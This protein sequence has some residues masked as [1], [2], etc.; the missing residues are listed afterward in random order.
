MLLPCS[1]RDQH[2][3]VA[4][5]LG[6]EHGESK[7]RC[8]HY[9]DIGAGC[10]GDAHDVFDLDPVSGWTVWAPVA[11]V[12]DDPGWPLAVMRMSKGDSRGVELLTDPTTACFACQVTCSATRSAALHQHANLDAHKQSAEQAPA[13]WLTQLYTEHVSITVNRAHHA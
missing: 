10:W 13:Q 2:H 9:R 3:E 12:A 4:E 7:A 1:S 5:V 6:P 11:R 8:C